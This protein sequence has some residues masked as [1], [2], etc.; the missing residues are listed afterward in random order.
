MLSAN[1][2]IRD[3]PIVFGQTATLGC[4][5]EKDNETRLRS[6]HGGRYN[7]PL[8]VGNVSNYPTKYKEVTTHRPFGSKLLIFNFNEDDVDCEYKCTIGLQEDSHRLILN[9]R[10]FLCK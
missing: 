4:I 1:W 9:K 2:T 6:W 3:P 5:A 8:T 10:D 7:I